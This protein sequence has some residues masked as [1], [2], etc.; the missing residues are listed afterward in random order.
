MYSDHFINVSD[1]FID[2]LS[3]LLTVMLKHGSTNI[4]INKSIIKPIPKD[5][6]KSLSDS[7]NY[8]AISKNSMISKIIDYVIMQLIK[9]KMVTSAYQFGYKE[10]F[11]TSLC[12]FLVSETIQYY[13]SK[14]SNVYMT[15]LD[16]TK[17]FDRIQHTKL[18]KT[19]IDK[20]ICP[21]IIRLIMNSYI[22]STAIVKW[23]NS[24]SLPLNINNGVK[25]GGILS[26]PL[27]AM[28]INPLIEKLN[29]S[30]QG[31]HIGHLAANAFAYADDI[32]LLSPSCQALRNLIDITEKFANEYKLDF[33][34]QKCK[35]L[36]YSKD[37]TII[38]N[39]DI[40][41][42][43]HKIEI[44]QAEKHLGH[45]FQNKRNIINMDNIIKDI[46]V[47]TNVIIN[48]FKPIA[49]QAKV[50]LFQSQCS[51]LYGCQ[52]W[53]LDD[54]MVSRLCTTWNI[55]SRKILGLSAQTRSFLLHQVMDTLP[56]KDVIMN[57]IMNFFV[58][59]LNHTN[60]IIS[61]FFKN[62][63]FSNSSYMSTNINRII[64]NYN[65]QYEDI[66]DLNK[67]QIKRIIKQ[68]HGEPDWRSNLVRELLDIRD[69]QVNC[70]LTPSEAKNLLFYLSTYR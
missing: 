47:R 12:S 30:K 57:R 60:K 11:S 18:F 22:M 52:L 49:W 61:D 9:D 32:V 35:M 1:C 59:G 16:C 39:I 17:A 43:G 10:N 21:S 66:F 67:A 36:V 69:G 20:D 54:P 2:V 48:K 3:K 23:N 42:R 58:H 51:S 33:N 37:Q 5:K 62:T 64:H 19:L 13:R 29:D 65:I 24:T 70:I 40:R 46:K 41:I 28:Y 27:F 6:H 31:C 44:V 68:V 15:L 63:L 38:N 4:L 53:N 26:A 50:T 45:V 55:C 34:P 8:R 25:Q 56:I 7:S 14:N